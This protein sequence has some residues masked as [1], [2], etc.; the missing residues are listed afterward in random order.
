MSSVLLRSAPSRLVQLNVVELR[1]WNPQTGLLV[2]FVV[3]ELIRERLIKLVLVWPQAS[4]ASARCIEVITS[5]SCSATAATATVVP[6]A[7]KSSKL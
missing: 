2:G 1:V 3:W 5:V 6:L 4:A 7:F